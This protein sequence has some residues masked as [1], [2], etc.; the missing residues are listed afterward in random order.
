MKKLFTL[1]LAL[2]GFAGVSNAATVDELAVLKHSYVLVGDDW[3]NNGTEKIA[4]NALFGDNHFFTPTGHDK[5]TNKGSIDLSSVD[6]LGIVTEEIAKKYGE[7]GSHLNSLRLKT[8]QDV[9]AI[10]VTA[11]S[12]VIIFYENNKALRYPIFAKDAKLENKLTSDADIKASGEIGSKGYGRIE[13]TAED[14]GV[15]YVG[16]E[17]QIFVSY[18]I[19]EAN[20]APGTPQVKLGDQKFEGGLWY[21]EVSCKA[22]EA[23]GF[24]TI[25]TYTTDGTAPTAAS[26]VYTAPIKCYNNMTVKFQA[27]MD[28]GTGAADEAAILPGADNEVPVSFAFDAPTINADGANVTISSPYA[29]QNGSNFYKI[30]DADAVKGDSFTLTE[31]ATVTA[32]TEIAN[33]SYGTFLSKNSTKDVYVLNPIKSKKIIA[34]TAG[35]VV[36]DEEATETSTTGPVYKVENGAI[37]ADKMDFF[38]KNLEFA[39]VTNEDYQVDGET[40][41]IKMNN[42]NITFMVADGDSVTVKV[43]CS[44]NSCKNI[45]SESASDRQCVINVSGTTYMVPGTEVD[46][47]GNTLGLAPNE[48]GN[49]IEF[50]LT[51]GTYTFQKYSGTGNILIKSIEITPATAESETLDLI[52]RFTS[53][54]NGSETNTHNDDGTVTYNAVQ[55]GGLAAWIGGEDWSEYE[56]IVFEFAEPTTFATQ[57]FLQYA[58]GTETKAWINDGAATAECTLEAGKVAVNQA[59]L[60]CAEAGTLTITKI[61]LV[62]ASAGISNMQAVTPVHSGAIYNLA[63]QKVDANYRGVVIVNGK[64]MLQK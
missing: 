13:W 19:V 51:G 42:T 46:D 31:S 47:K 56:K 49:V 4:K 53:C 22:V 8:S 5:A 55:W 7:Y 3:T 44:K 14:D 37:S 10:S 35:E 18:V 21:R 25:V 29:E 23:E 54:W 1:A 39:V 36:L 52:D 9:F 26:P 34:V 12:K 50:G 17:N 33:G 62:K 20:E 2:L 11:K 48:G 64:K 16:A 60:Q 28:L 6:E 40:R 27:F 43:V 41:Y 59:A 45:D 30:G 32:Y 57:I 61:Y 24:P 15:V 58:D 63:G 38:V